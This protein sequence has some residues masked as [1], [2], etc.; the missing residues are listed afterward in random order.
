V[1]HVRGA[2]GDPAGT[3]PPG[4]GTF[5]ANLFHCPVPMPPTPTFTAAQLVR[6]RMQALLL[7]PARTKSAPPTP[8]RIV[9]HYL[10]TQAQDFRA[11]RWA[12]G[13]R[14]PGCTEAEVL[15]ACDRG[16]IVRSWPMRGT[17]HFVAADDLPWM[18]E[19]LG[20]RALMGVESRWNHLGLT[21]AMLER[22][23]EVAVAHL[24]GGRRA[25]RA[26]LGKAWAAAGLD[27]SGQR[28]YHTVWY[29]SQTG[30]LVQG[31]TR[32]ND[33]ELVLLDEWIPSPRRLGRDEALADL[34]VRYLTARGPVTADDLVHWTKLT[35]TDA[36]KAFA[37][38]GPAVC[39][40]EGPGG[41]YHILAE[42]RDTLDPDHPAVD[43]SVHALAAFD[44]HLLGYRVRDL[45]LDP[46]HATRVD[47]GRNGVFRWTLVH[48]GRVVGTWKR[49]RRTHHVVVDVTPFS[50][51]PRDVRARTEEALTRWGTFAGTEL[52]VRW[53]GR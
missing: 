7:A 26:E 44:E 10:A 51:L 18:L 23:R 46:E 31:P 25:T 2:H 36:R 49:T 11:S 6:L 33:H 48:G 41:P 4:V 34:A 40:V 19:H 21:K 5:P 30:T 27:L 43:A 1:L 3:V 29:L 16:E 37:L 42:Q 20:P 47:P 45:V 13:S 35:R 22:A 28:T 17:V 24:E 32:G 53:E 8:A 15:A 14:I 50:P 39:T 52:Q 38:A 9:S 12:V